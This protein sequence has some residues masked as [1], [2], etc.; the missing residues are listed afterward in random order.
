MIGFAVRLT[1]RGGREALIRT[2]V[3]A[4]AVALG[5]GLLLTTL[6]GV[7]AVNK[8]N[9]RYAWLETGAGGH[10]PV[11]PGTS[12]T[13]WRLSADEFHG[14]VI[15]RVDVAP[16]GPRPPVPPGI[17]ALPG[18]GEFYASPAMTKLLQQSGPAALRNRYPGRQIGDIGPTGLPAP[19]S[20]IVVVGDTVGQLSHANDADL[21]DAISTTSPSSCNGDCFAIGIDSNGISL[22]LSVVAVALLF[23]LLIFLGVASRLSAAQREMRFA[24]MRLVG[25]TPRQV[26]LVSTVESTLAAVAGMAVGFGLF[27]ALRPLLAPLPFTGDPFYVSDLALT[28]LQIVLV[29]LGVPLGAAVASRLAL[30]RVT[31]SPLGVTRR[32]TPGPPRPYRLILLCAGLAELGYFAI[33]GRPATTN[34]QILAFTSGILVTM[35]GLIIA[36][37]WLTMCG[38]R[39][40]ARRTSSPSGLVAARRLA[41]DPKAGFR[42]I[43]GLVLG[44]FVGSVAVAVMTTIN[45][46][47]G[48]GATTAAARAT[49]IDDFRTFTD[50]GPTSLVPSIPPSVLSSLR[51]IPG[52]KKYAIVR[53]VP[54]RPPDM[55]GVVSCADLTAN[56]GLGSCGRRT[57]TAMFESGLLGSRDAPQHGWP[58]SSYAPDQLAGLPV[59]AL[60]VTTDGSHAAIE[61]VRTLLER[62][63]P[64]A[65]AHRYPPLT[66]AESQNQSD[67]AKRNASYQRLADVVI[68]ATLPIAGCTLAVGIIAG[69]NDRR[70]PFGLLRLTGA[71]VGLLRRV[72]MFES[73]VPLLAGA[74][75][76]VGVGFLT[77]YLFLRAQLSE[78]LHSPGPGFY[79]VVF[80]GVAA[81]LIVVASTFPVLRRLTGPEAVR[82]D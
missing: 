33:A 70:R 81:S 32:V 52:V 20:L 2:I 77:S 29:A 57:G 69:L 41:N 27:F 55:S 82:N 64:Y 60:A 6:A 48:R 34:G 63:F 14:K 22:V 58:P 51:E 47:D 4:A 71:P 5:V 62:D 10:P 78:T 13:W 38:S 42:A 76:A 72:I 37:P 56:P 23:P 1:L 54:P 19:T 35:A 65:S 21:V 59:A 16:T 25:A 74:L 18:P 9:A 67:S 17:P 24:A 7:T 49:L 68:L 43:S 11:A 40:V 36:G 12:P 66:I 75:A 26:T 28:P 79:G 50:N 39:L 44:L 30:R 53:E 8:Q 45:A 80:A 73:A 3:I 31:I 46:Y 15:G 61:E